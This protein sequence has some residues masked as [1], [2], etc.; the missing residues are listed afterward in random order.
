VEPPRHTFF[1]LV[2]PVMMRSIA[3]QVDQ[4]AKQAPA[5]PEAVVR[6]FLHGHR[7]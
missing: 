5:D 7:P 2:G 6:R 3:R 4:R 1:A